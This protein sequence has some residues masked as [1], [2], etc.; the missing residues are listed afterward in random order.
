MWAL[1][2]RIFGGRNR[3]MAQ[4]GKPIR[5]QKSQELKAKT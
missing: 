3:G 1:S 4:I 2:G 5:R